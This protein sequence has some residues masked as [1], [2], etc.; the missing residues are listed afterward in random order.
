MTVI[1]GP[2]STLLSL[3]PKLLENT[4]VLPFD[5]EIYKMANFASSNKNVPIESVIIEASSK[6]T[7]QDYTTAAGSVPVITSSLTSTEIWIKLP[8]FA[9]VF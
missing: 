7:A 3:P 2:D 5:G 1:Y 4:D 6:G 9:T 8:D